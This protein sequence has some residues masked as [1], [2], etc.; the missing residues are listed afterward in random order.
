[1]LNQSVQ[2]SNSDGSKWVTDPMTMLTR[3]TWVIIQLNEG[4]PI[5]CNHINKSLGK[6]RNSRNDSTSHL[7]IMV[8]ELLYSLY[9]LLVAYAIQV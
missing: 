8:A 2:S 7:E 6:T 1:M 9:L 5:L 4:Q 3:V